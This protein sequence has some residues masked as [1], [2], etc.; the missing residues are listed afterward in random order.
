MYDNTSVAAH[1][2]VWSQEGTIDSESLFRVY[3]ASDSNGTKVYTIVEKPSVDL[4]SVPQQGLVH[5]SLP[6]DFE[7][8]GKLNVH[9]TVG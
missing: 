5:H 8:D 6:V 7:L 4:I 3:S 9:L 1:D 2:T